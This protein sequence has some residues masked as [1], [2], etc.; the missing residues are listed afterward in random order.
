[1]ADFD[2]GLIGNGGGNLGQLA[3]AVNQQRQQQQQQLLSNLANAGTS[4]KGAFDQQD[5]DSALK[6][7]F[8]PETQQLNQ[9]GV[10]ADLFKANPKSAMSL[11]QQFQQQ[12]LAQQKVAN[13]TLEANSKVNFQNA[14]AN[15]F[16]ADAQV[17][18]LE[19]MLKATNQVSQLISAIDPNDPNRQEKYERII[20]YG[21]KNNLPVDM[22]RGREYNSALQKEAL[23][24]TVAGADQLKNEIEKV[25]ANIDLFKANTDA[26]RVANQNVNEQA[27]N[28][29]DIRG[30]DNQAQIAANNLEAEREKSNRPSQE[31]KFRQSEKAQE[32]IDKYTDAKS[33]LEQANIG[34]KDIQTKAKTFLNNPLINA[35]TERFII[36]TNLPVLGTKEKAFKADYDNFISQVIGETVSNMRAQSVNGTSIF[37]Q[38]TQGEQPLAAAQGGAKTYDQF[39]QLPPEDRVK[40]LNDFVSKTQ[41]AIDNNEKVIKIGKQKIEKYNQNLNPNLRIERGDSQQAQGGLSDATRARMDAIIAA[42]RYPNR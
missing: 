13:D 37:G 36:S 33:R 6:N 17:Q 11:N 41:Q 18:Q 1:M 27:K 38:F 31:L 34:I 20:S 30:Q 7:N 16:N 35:P 9:K 26:T 2:A 22:F 40:Y 23:Y 19:S 21:E 28:L 39:I 15:K 3:L 14:Q 4:I 10:I 12:Q 25:K 8:D 29:T 32:N 5:I 42:G 24:S